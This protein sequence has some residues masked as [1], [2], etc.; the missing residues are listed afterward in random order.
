MMFGVHFSTILTADTITDPWLRGVCRALDEI[1]GSVDAD[2]IDRYAN[3]GAAPCA[4]SQTIG[5]PCPRGGPL[6]NKTVNDTDGTAVHR[7]RE[8]H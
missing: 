1:E 3:L 6:S 2:T 5:P 7:R 8:S 4:L